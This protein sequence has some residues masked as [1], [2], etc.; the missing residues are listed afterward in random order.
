MTRKH[1]PEMAKLTGAAKKNPQ[2]YRKQPP[3]SEYGIGAPPAHL[4]KDH[5]TIWNELVKYGLPGT[6][7]GSDR[8]HLESTVRLVYKMRFPPSYG[9]TTAE[10]SLLISSLSKLGMNPQDRN[11]LGVQPAPKAKSKKEADDFSEFK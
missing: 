7:T 10:N 2:R 1:T 5:K 3:K 8:V 4:D 11:R 9:F 6:L